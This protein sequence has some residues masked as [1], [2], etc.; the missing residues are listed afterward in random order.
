MPAQNLNEIPTWF[1]NKPIS[2]EYFEELYVN[3]DRGRGMIPYK[4]IA[5]R[6]TTNPDGNYKFLFAGYKGCGKSTELIRLEREIGK[7][8]LVLNFSIL[9]E[10]DILNLHYIE[11]FIATM[12][13]LFHVAKEFDIPIR[14]ELIE[15]IQ[16]WLAEKEIQEVHDKYVGMDVEGG[17]QAKGGIPFFADF[18]AKF[19]AAAK[20]SS[21]IKEVLTNKIEPRLSEFIDNCNLLINEI[22]GKLND[23]GKKDLLI[24]I[25][26]LDKM[27]LDRAEDIFYFHSS[28]L[29]QLNTH[30]IFTFPIALV[31][32]IRFNTINHN[33]DRSLILPMIKVYTKEGEPYEEG[34]IA[35]REIIG[36]RMDTSLFESDELMEQFIEKSGGC[37]L[38]LFR[39]ITAAAENAVIYEDQ[40]ITDKNY[41]SAYYR[42]RFAYENTIADNPKAGLTADDYYSAL[43]EAAND[44]LKKPKNREV[45]LHL[46]QNL[47]ILGYNETEWCD[48]HPIIRDILEERNML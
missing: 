41:E 24:I 20:S 14:E 45:M 4:E 29:T 35:L 2:Q 7:D 5:N 6:L 32:N 8:F 13:K 19:K 28:Q 47:S 37:L 46:R 12:E 33:Y 38:D 11:L 48:I 17:V 26:D 9:E 10:L 15:N 16:K 43:I 27:Y 36:R 42:I 39:M 23:I 40:K 22:R 31:Y 18:F 34:R 3:A 1:D 30:C 21:S 25:E 44:P